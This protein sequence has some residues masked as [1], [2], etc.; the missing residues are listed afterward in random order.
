MALISTWVSDMSISLIGLWGGAVIIIGILKHKLEYVKNNVVLLS[1]FSS[2]LILTYLLVN[3]SK[4]FS[5]Q[6]YNYYL[7][8]KSQTV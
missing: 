4:V 6:E 8:V 2:L 5:T 7:F 3:W 1:I